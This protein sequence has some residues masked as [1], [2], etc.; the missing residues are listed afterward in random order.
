MPSKKTS[1]KRPAKNSSAKKTKTQ[2]AATKSAKPTSAKST[3][4][5][6][7]PEVPQAPRG[8]QDILP[9][10]QKY[11]EYAVETAK[12]V[13]R[14]FGFHRIDTPIFEDRAL[15]ERSVGEDTDIVSKEMFE[16]KSRGRGQQYVLRPEGTAPIA[17]AY[18]EHGMRAWPKPIKL[19]YTGPFFRYERPQAGRFRQHHQLGVEV[20]GSTA[21]VTDAQLIFIAH[22]MCQELGL[23]NYT[24]R[25]NS[26]GRPE[27]RKEY[28]KLLKDHYRRNRS[29]MCKDCKVR[30]KTNPLRVLDC[31]EEKCQQLANTAPRLLDHL[32]DESREHFE[33]V[34][35]TLDELEVPYDV[36]P[37][38]VRGLDYYSHTVFEFVPKSEM[39]GEQQPT[40]I[41][42]GRYNGLIKQIGGKDTPGVGWSSGI[43]RIVSRIKEES[44]ELAVTDAPQIFIAHLGE[45]AKHHALLVMRDLQKASIPF[46][47]GLD[48]DG[49]QAQ[50]KL[51]D[52]LNVPWVLI[53]GH[54][55][56][57]DKTVILRSMDSGMQEVIP[58]SEMV[59]ELRRRLNIPSVDEDE[60]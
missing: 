42:G 60:S 20:F 48:R 59:H 5:K 44:I 52:R 56:V 41:A 38:L 8:T 43:E 58:R 24:I 15:F 13:V 32:K 33:S 37:S 4:K 14:G 54:K 19:F 36:A 47:E 51:A 55:E 50:L 16:I 17:R 28:I 1:K 12:S 25:V 34:L 9:Q 27:E 2:A 39:P 3:P 26:I 7:R 22:T 29:K 10:E 40:F 57:I 46:A 35:K 31:K 53:I 11:W 18:L 30:L 21:P 23:E 45:Q 6:P 49:M